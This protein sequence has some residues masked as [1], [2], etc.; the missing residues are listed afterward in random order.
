VLFYDADGSGDLSERREYVFGDWD[1]TATSDLEALRSVFDTNGDGKLSGSELDNFRVMVTQADGTTIV[2]TMTQLGITEIDLMGDATHIELPDGSVI[3][4]QTT[5]TM[6]GQTRTVGEM[7]LATDGRGYR[8]EETESTSGGVTTRDIEAYGAGG[9]LAW[10]IHVV[11][12]TD[13]SNTVNSYDDDGDG[14]VDRVQECL[15][16]GKSRELRVTTPE[17]DVEYARVH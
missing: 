5:F 14:I 7:V 16:R 15:L 4:G 11:A 9:E 12:A 8:L 3:T 2:Q 17:R 13:G 1:P 6:N 10:A